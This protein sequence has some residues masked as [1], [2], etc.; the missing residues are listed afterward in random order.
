MQRRNQWLSQGR[1]AEGGVKQV[2]G[3]KRFKLWV[4]NK[5]QGCNVQDREIYKI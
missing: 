2:K 5:T 1:G 3:I 4:I